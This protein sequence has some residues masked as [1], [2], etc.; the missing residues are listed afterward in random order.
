[1]VRIYRVLPEPNREVRLRNPHRVKLQ[2]RRASR[3][4]PATDDGGGEETVMVDTA[5]TSPPAN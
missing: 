5:T 4:V 1:M 2:P 3:P